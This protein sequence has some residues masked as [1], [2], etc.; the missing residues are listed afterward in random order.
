MQ[1]IRLRTEYLKN[2]IGIDIVKPRFGWNCEG[3]TTQTAYQI[4]VQ[5]GKEIYWDSGKVTSS[6]MH[7]IPYE[8]KALQSREKLTWSVVLWD[9]NDAAEQPKEQA[10]F[11]MGL[12]K[13]E[14]W[15]AKWITGDYKPEKNHRYPADCFKKDFS[16]K[17]EVASARLYMSAC[18]VY[19]AYLN[20]KR[21]GN[22]ELAPGCTD[23]RYRLQYQTYDVADL[24]AK[25]TSFELLLGD[26]WYRGSIGCFGKTNVFGRETKVLAQLEIT[27]KDGTC[28]TIITDDNFAWSNDGA[29]RFNDFK[30]GE[31]VNANMKPSYRG[32]AKETL[33]KL[34]P[35][36]SNN[37]PVTAHEEFAGK[38]IT[39]P[40]G[41][42]VI[43]FG[44]NLAGFLEF[45]VKGK[46]GQRILLT[47]G[48]ILDENG[49]FTQKNMV[50]RKPVKEFGQ[51]TEIMMITGNSDK[52]KGE[53]QVTPMQ[54]V[55]FTCS[56]EEDF[57][58]TKFAL[59]GFR[60]ALIET[61]ANFNATD[62]KA[63]AAY[64]DMEETGQFSCSNEKVNQLFSNIKWSMKSNFLDVPTDCPTRE[65]L[66]W[67]GDAQ[68]FF[69]SSSYLYD[70]AA[71]YRK[72]MVDIKDDQYKTGKVSA[73][74]PYQ[75]LS[76]LYDNTGSSVGWADAV[77]LIPYRYY[78]VYKD[79]RILEDTYEM[80]KKYAMFMIKNAGP[81]K[82]QD[83]P[84]IAHRKYVYEKGFH[85]GEWLEPEEFKDN[86]AAGVKIKH[87]EICTAYLHL[88]MSCMEEIADVL[89]YSQDKALFEEYAKG[90]KAAYQEL[91]LQQVPDTNRQA[92]L[93]RP[94]AFSLAEG[95]EKVAITERL[96]K[97][98]DY[99]EYRVGTGFLSTVSLLPTLTQVGHADIAYKV[100]ENEQMPGWLYEVNQG[101]TTIWENWEGT[102]SHNHY[103]PGAVCEWMFDTV[104][105]INVVGENEFLI[106]PI[107]GGSLKNAKA[108]YLS[109]Y[110]KVRV[111]WEKTD[112]GYQYQVEVPAN[113]TAKIVLPDGEQKMIT[114]GEYVFVG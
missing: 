73:V 100:F 33:C 101:A 60:Y 24:L 15:K 46:K 23:Y 68:I 49:E 63:V 16:L 111:S 62:F 104:A 76:M 72:W 44:Q 58:R 102:V 114:A 95:E 38:L 37:V 84:E 92:V 21:V 47:L 31:I 57:Y 27:Y 50:E 54:Q 32:K 96:L 88:T 52:V 12:L 41:K 5:K 53:L 34:I 14:D 108:E 110:G 36:A 3:G 25:E 79:K 106:R 67:T 85:L 107:P 55:I 6:S 42:K 75:G 91:F 8:G 18:G 13:A 86:I 103:S 93:V 81:A 87:T 83:Y 22:F 39:T 80:C 43:D 71:F 113:T 94:L 98:L 82:K 99:Y 20:G 2:P 19:E 9:E 4:I 112:A 74:V 105:G 35:T 59:F 17:G 109:P 56:G 30:D 11:E 40:S 69:K 1:A 10:F 78:Q 97:A 7:L 26:G 45:K 48:E 29:I 51:M 70:V 61:K 64:S 77:V 90:A 89:G 28:E 65:R 66:G